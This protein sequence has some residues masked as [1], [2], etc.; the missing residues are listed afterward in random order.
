[1]DYK[2]LP[3]ST[4]EERILAIRGRDRYDEGLRHLRV[5]ANGAREGA[6]PSFRTRAERLISFEQNLDDDRRGKLRNMLATG[7]A[8][9]TEEAL[10]LLEQEIEDS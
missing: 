1:M 2:A 5:V 9:S 3:M 6:L 4:Q 8:R 10:L 7:A